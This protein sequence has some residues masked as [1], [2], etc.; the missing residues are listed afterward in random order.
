MKI[1]EFLEK[2][3]Y[4]IKYGEEILDINLKNM[5]LVKIIFSN[6][7]ETE[8][9]YFYLNIKTNSIYLIEYQINKEK[10]LYLNNIIKKFIS[11]DF[12]SNKKLIKNIDVVLNKKIE[13]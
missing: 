11:K 7:S 10:Y 5:S 9:G 8:F 13:D 4:N 12:L 6:D 3:N 2:I 1:N